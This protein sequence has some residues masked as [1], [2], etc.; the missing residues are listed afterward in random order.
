[1]SYLFVVSMD[2]DP[3]HEDLFNDVYDNEHVPFLMEVDGVNRVTRGK[4]QAFAVAIGGGTKTVDAAKPSYTAIYE[5][6]DP[7]VLA[8]DAWAAAVEKGRW[9]SEVRPHTS[10]RHHAVF[11]IS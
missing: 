8:S 6:D 10:N 9:P 3:A 5:I 7:A 11:K 4:S 2:V 1:M